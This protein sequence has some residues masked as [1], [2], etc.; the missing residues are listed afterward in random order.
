MFTTPGRAGDVCGVRDILSSFLSYAGYAVN[1]AAAGCVWG[2][3]GGV[4]DCVSES[5]ENADGAATC[6]D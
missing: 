3:G 5:K 1:R 2:C 4:G 6:G